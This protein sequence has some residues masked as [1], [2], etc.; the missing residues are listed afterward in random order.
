MLVTLDRAHNE[1]QMALL[2]ID[3]DK[4]LVGCLD[5]TAQPEPFI[6]DLSLSHGLKEL[7]GLDKN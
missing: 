3:L 4:I 2:G 7:Q 1:A 5:N 6:N